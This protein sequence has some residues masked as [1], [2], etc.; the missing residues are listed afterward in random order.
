[1]SIPPE[2]ALAPPTDHWHRLP[3]RGASLAATS[4]ALGAGVAGLAGWLV[5][6]STA[7][8][9]A[10]R[11]GVWPVIA[12]L[13]VLM[14][15][16][17]WVGWRRQRAVRWRLDAQGLALRQ[18]RLWQLETRV[19]LS[20]VQHLDLKRGPIERATGLATVI[21]HTAGTHMSAVAVPGLD[22]ADAERLRDR[23]AH[24]LDSHD[25]AL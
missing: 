3:A 21:V 14:L 11:W 10:W 1:M 6:A 23:L 4:A 9:H 13:V 17:A 19:P 25:D 2:A 18:G 15:L 5:A 22:Q 16:A 20:R 7:L 8:R 24:Q 12:S